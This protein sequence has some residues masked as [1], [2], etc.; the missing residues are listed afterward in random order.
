MLKEERQQRI[1]AILRKNGKVIATE[2]SASLN[3]SEDTVR[4]DLNEMAEAGLLQRVYGGAIPRTPT[5]LAFHAREQEA[6][7][8]K[9]A[10]AAA[11]LPLFHDGQ[12]IIMDGGT[13]VLQVA[14]SLPAE[15]RGT[16]ITSSIPVLQTLAEHPNLEV[17]GVGGRLFKEFQSM[18]GAHTVAAYR[19][20][21][22]DIAIMGMS[23]MHPD[24]GLCILDNEDAA[25]KAA[26]VEGSREVVAVCASDKIGAIAPFIF[27]PVSALTHL[28]TDSETS[29]E[30]LAPYKEMGIT[31]LRG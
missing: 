7:D 25:V 16:V 19:A 22:A 2:L 31:V 6:I 4:R 9:A 1:L 5:M 3:T 18:N 11:C 26:M 8:A 14:R 30:A 24:V 20:F 27:A 21:R 12:V 15:L 29:E 17:I 13:T 23:G 28:V 10:I